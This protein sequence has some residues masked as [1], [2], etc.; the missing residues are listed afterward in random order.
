LNPGNSFSPLRNIA[1][2]MKKS[3]SFLPKEGKGFQIKL[4]IGKR[5][6]CL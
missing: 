6:N 3:S 4:A 1:Q 2:F 5:A